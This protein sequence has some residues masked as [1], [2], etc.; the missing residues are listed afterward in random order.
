MQGTKKADKFPKWFEDN[1]TMSDFKENL[2]EYKNKKNLK[3]LQIGVFT[4]NASAWLMENILTDQSCIL[5]DVDP[6][7]GNLQHES[8]YDWKELEDAY[9]EQ[10]KPYANRVKKHKAYSEEWLKENR[11]DKYD[12][13]Y[14]DGDHRPEAVTSD[15]ELSWGLL[16]PKGIM[17]FDDYEW[18]HPDGIDLNPKPAIDKFLKKYANE[19][20]IIKMGWQVWVRKLG[21]K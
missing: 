18:N 15:A 9:D 12:F 2:K 17:A 11:D 4:G 10:V 13:I 7:C 20:E 5:V 19:L 8:I 6:W 21:T 14:I 16:K 3:F 1:N